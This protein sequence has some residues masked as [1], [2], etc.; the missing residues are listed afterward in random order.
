ME[1]KI[2]KLRKIGKKLTYDNLRWL[3][4]W[5]GFKYDRSDFLVIFDELSN[6]PRRVSLGSSGAL[7]EGCVC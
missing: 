5:P 4:I 7:L 3:Y 2:S 6:A 1:E